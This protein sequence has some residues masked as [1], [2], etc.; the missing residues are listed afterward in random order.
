LERQISCWLFIAI[1][2]GIA[3]LVFIPVRHLCT[4]HF[5]WFESKETSKQTSAPSKAKQKFSSYI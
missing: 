5:P 2:T 3:F 4:K 1:S